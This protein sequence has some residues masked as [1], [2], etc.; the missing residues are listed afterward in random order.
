MLEKLLSENSHSL[1]IVFTGK[2]M[3]K[4]LTLVVD[5]FIL[6]KVANKLLPLGIID[7]IQG[8]NE[9]LVLVLGPLINT[10]ARESCLIIIASCCQQSVFILNEISIITLSDKVGILLL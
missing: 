8:A 6:R 3:I 1:G 10:P 4:S 2:V 5:L 9:A 7:L